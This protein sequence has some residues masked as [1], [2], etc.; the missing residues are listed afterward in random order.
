[1]GAKSLT[2]REDGQRQLVGD[3]NWDGFKV[4]KDFEEKKTPGGIKRDRPK[5]INTQG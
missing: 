3:D 2:W 5:H 1:M 4:I